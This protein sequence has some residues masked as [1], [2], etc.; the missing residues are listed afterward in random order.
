LKILCYDARSEKRQITL[1]P[2][3]QRAQIS[4]KITSQKLI[5]KKLLAINKEPQEGGKREP[6]TWSQW[7]GPADIHNYVFV[8][9]TQLQMIAQQSLYT[10]YSHRSCYMTPCILVMAIVL[11]NTAA[12]S[13]AWKKKTVSGFVRNFGAYLPDLV[14]THTTPP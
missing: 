3:K 5:L 11:E 12:C 9:C 14:T 6:I 10:R 2:V 7:A 13:A 8:Y 4:E 1:L